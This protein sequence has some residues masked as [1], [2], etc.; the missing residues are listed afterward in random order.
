MRPVYEWE[1]RKTGIKPEGP[2]KK[3]KWF[4]TEPDA[5]LTWV[6]ENPSQ[7]YEW[8]FMIDQGLPWVL[9][10]CPDHHDLITVRP[11]NHEI[12][13]HDGFARFK[14]ITLSPSLVCPTCQWHV[15]IERSGV[16]DCGF[17]VKGASSGG[18]PL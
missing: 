1:G 2:P 18:W 3:T 17:G 10:F 11:E 4:R 7:P 9:I 6:Q 13:I 12:T 5:R 15:F 14:E 8:S 16:Y